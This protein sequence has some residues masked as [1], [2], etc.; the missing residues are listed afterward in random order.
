MFARLSLNH[1]LF[2]A[3]MMVGLLFG[4]ELVRAAS[5]STSVQSPGRVAS[6][7]NGGPATSTTSSTRTS[8]AA[9]QVGK[10][11]GLLGITD[12]DPVGDATPAGAR[13]QVRDAEWETF[14][15]TAYCSCTKCCGRN[16]QG[17]TASGLK[18]RPGHRVVAVDTRFIALRSLVEI[19]GMG[20]FAALDTGS[21]IKG[22]RVDVWMPDHDDALQFGRRKIRLRVVS[23]GGRGA[24]E[25]ARET[26][27]EGTLGLPT[28]GKS[29]RTRGAAIPATVA[30]EATNNEVRSAVSA[31]PP[32]AAVIATPDGSDRAV[33]DADDGC[34]A[35]HDEA[36]VALLPTNG[37]GRSAAGVWG[38]ETGGLAGGS[39]VDAGAAE[40]GIRGGA[41]DLRGEGAAHMAGGLWL[42]DVG[43]VMLCIWAVAA[44]VVWARRRS[45]RVL[46]VASDG[47]VARA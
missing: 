1:C 43:T 5:G 16:A 21:A 45:G 27:H 9:G 22:R 38:G 14:V 39:P 12:A 10:G 13:N 44:G 34:P 40:A 19:D 2:A 30:P 33:A 23:K 18:L 15:A 46:Q 31:Q 29:V 8:T 4:A 47:E 32:V 25:P 24:G 17:I 37:G 20:R 6:V 28:G 11:G 26:W 35:E 7:G 36:A 42:S 41:A 3:T